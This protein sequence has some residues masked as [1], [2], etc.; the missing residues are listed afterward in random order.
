MKHIANQMTNFY[1]FQ[2]G[3]SIQLMLLL[4]GEHDQQF[5]CFIFVQ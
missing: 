5:R 1:E 3:H 4:H 2:I